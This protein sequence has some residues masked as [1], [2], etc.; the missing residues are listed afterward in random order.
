[1]GDSGRYFTAAPGGKF[2]EKRR[3]DLTGDIGEGVA[4]KEKERSATMTLPEEFY[5]F[6]ERD[7]LLLFFFPLAAARCLSL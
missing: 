5:E 3:D 6:G 2:G 7:D 4:V 1:M